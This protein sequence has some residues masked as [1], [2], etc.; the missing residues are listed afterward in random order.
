ML[1]KSHLF[2][3]MGQLQQK[4]LFAA[5]ALNFFLQET[6]EEYLFKC[7]NWSVQKEDELGFCIGQN[8]KTHL[9]LVENQKSVSISAPKTVFI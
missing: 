1:E 8:R 2:L 7:E 9:T 4:L 5:I 6:A 3:K